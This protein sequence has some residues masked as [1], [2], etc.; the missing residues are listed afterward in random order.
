M[1]KQLFAAALLV[2][3]ASYA[4]LTGYVIVAL[5]LMV[6]TILLL[7]YVATH[8]YALISSWQTWGESME[9]QARQL[10]AENSELKAILAK[11]GRPNVVKEEIAPRKSILEARHGAGTSY[12]GGKHA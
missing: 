12:P 9:E 6:A 3:L 11:R 4:T 7:V 1:F 10:T 2:L 8:T 5:A